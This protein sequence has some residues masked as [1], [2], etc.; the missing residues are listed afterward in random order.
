M[1]QRLAVTGLGAVSALGFG[2]DAVFRRLCAGERGVRPVTLFDPLDARCKLAA[3]V[4]DLDVRAIA[5]VGEDG[6][7]RTDAMALVAARE[8]LG[9]AG[10]FGRLGITVGGTT[11]GMLET[12]SALL[13]GVA[14][15]VDDVVSQHRRIRDGDL[16]VLDGADAHHEQVLLHNITDGVGDLDAVSRTEGEHVGQHHTGDDVRH[17]RGRPEREQD[18]E[19]DR[20]PLEG[21]GVRT[22][23]VR[24]HDDRREGDHQEPHDLEGGLGPLLVE[25]GEPDVPAPDRHEDQPGAADQVPRYDYND[26]D[27]EKARQVT[28]YRQHHRKDRAPDV[29]EDLLRDTTRPREEPKDGLQVDCGK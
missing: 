6:W 19:E 20:N 28:A 10:A 12:E 24:E 29:A 3:E 2:A 1:F 15:V 8:A 4:P 21:G 14:R 18:A 17:G 26:R 9:Q 5:P 16:H 25:S 11:G 13:L 22:R 23:Q 27:V 7:S